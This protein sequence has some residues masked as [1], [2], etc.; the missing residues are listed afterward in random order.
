MEHA[1]PIRKTG[2]QVSF[3]KGMKKQGGV[4]IFIE[5]GLG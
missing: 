5:K 3:V 2:I 4:I 1:K